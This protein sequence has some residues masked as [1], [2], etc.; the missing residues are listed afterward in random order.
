MI[1]T[2]PH[3]ST[4]YQT[5]ATKFAAPGRNVRCAKCGHVWFQTPPEPEVEPE[6]EPEMAP[7][8]AEVPLAPMSPMADTTAV[9]EPEPEPMRHSYSPPMGGPMPVRDRVDTPASRRR[10]GFGRMFG[11][12]L[13]IVIIAAVAFA[14]VQYR[15][16]IATMWPKTASVYSALGLKVNVLGLDIRDVTPSTGSDGNQPVLV[17]KGRVVNI[18]E[19]PIPVPE[20][21]VALVDNEAREIYHWKFDPSIGTLGAGAS[22]EFMTRLN[23]PPQGA[24][25][26]DVRF[27]E[28]GEQ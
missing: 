5:D 4:R 10:G 13:L 9:N 17:L 18:T 16:M 1:L 20:L 11:W 27:V 22:A 19:H 24:K 21:R 26:I 25:T 14:A 6:P 8:A 28:A 3:C 12:L 2:C 7:V 15:Q 23:A